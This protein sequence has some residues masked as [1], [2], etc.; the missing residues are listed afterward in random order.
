MMTHSDITRLGEEIIS[1]IPLQSKQIQ[2]WSTLYDLYITSEEYRNPAIAALVKKAAPLASEALGLSHALETV[3]DSSA[4]LLRYI[5]VRQIIERRQKVHMYTL[6]LR[7]L[8]L[9]ELIYTNASLPDELAESDVIRFWIKR[10]HIRLVE[11]G[12]E[13]E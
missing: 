12:K 3:W 11:N 5:L 4:T 1:S 2:G 8:I 13:E 10:Y 6:L 7:K 9:S